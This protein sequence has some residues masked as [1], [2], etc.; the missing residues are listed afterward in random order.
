MTFASGFPKIDTDNVADVLDHKGMLDQGLA[1][2]FQPFPATCDKLA[3]W[4]YTIRGQ[5]VP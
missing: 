4:V 5:M 1:A 2:T 3:G